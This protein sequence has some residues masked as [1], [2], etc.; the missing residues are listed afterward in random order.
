MNEVCPSNRS[1]SYPKEDLERVARRSVPGKNITI[2]ARIDFAT[3]LLAS[4]IP[5][6]RD[7]VAVLA[8]FENGT[9][10]A[11]VEVDEG[12]NTLVITASQAGDRAS[13]ESLRARG[14]IARA[15][16]ALLDISTLVVAVAIA[17]L[18]VVVA[19]LVVAAA[20]VIVRLSGSL[21][22]SRGLVVGSSRGRVAAEGTAGPIPTLGALRRRKGTWWLVRRAAA[23]PIVP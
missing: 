16:F 12:I 3:A 22:R 7:G 5:D 4:D 2:R 17:T 21:G 10:T 11:V 15:V 18:V 20:I 9:T 13:R 1:G 14:N 19:T 8:L 23:S 6:T